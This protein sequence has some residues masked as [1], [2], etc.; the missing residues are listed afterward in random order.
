MLG[1]RALHGRHWGE[2]GSRRSDAGAERLKGFETPLA[3]ALQV[4]GVGGDL[5]FWRFVLEKRVE[6]LKTAA[7]MDSLS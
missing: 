4:L 7:E 6:R 2:R 5:F 3:M 1:R